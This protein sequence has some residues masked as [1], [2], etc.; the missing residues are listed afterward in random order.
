MESRSP[1]EYFKRSIFIPFIDHFLSQLNSRFNDRLKT[2]LPLEGLIPKNNK[3]Y[4]IEQIFKTSLMYQA[5]INISEQELRAEIIMWQKRWEKVDKLNLPSTATEA[6]CFATNVFPSI[7]ILL[8]IF[9]TLPVST[10]TA[11]RSFSNI[12]RLK[13]YL[14]STM[15]ENRLN[16]LALLN[17]HKE[18]NVDINNIIT[19]FATSKP[20]RMNLKDWS[21][22]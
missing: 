21:S 10:A 1:E 22:D 5:D 9:A 12:K 4:P 7:K 14:R 16:G 19:R 3:I 6:L 11:E 18:I 2:I 17:I 20:R 15:T 8:Q 13:T